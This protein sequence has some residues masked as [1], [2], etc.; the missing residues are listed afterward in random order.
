ML[1]SYR[2][3]PVITAQRAHANFIENYISFVPALMISGLRFPVA[4]AAL[5]GI[6][7]LGRVLYAA[8]YTSSGPKGRRT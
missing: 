7:V 1:I 6:W 8:G 2:P 3:S 5:G 4:S